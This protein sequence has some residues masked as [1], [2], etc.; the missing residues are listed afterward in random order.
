MYQRLQSQGDAGLL[1]EDIQAIQYAY[2]NVIPCTSHKLKY[3][4]QTTPSYCLYN[5]PFSITDHCKYLGVALH[6]NA[7]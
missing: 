5:A 6:S 3:T 7:I 4:R 1:Q 2:P